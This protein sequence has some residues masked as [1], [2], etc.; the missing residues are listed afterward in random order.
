M[1][2]GKR[3][4]VYQSET[5]VSY[6]YF[7]DCQRRVVRPEGQGAGT[8]FI[9]VVSPDQRV[10][11]VLRIFVADRALAAWREHRG[12]ELDSQEQ[13]V[14]AKMRLFRGFDE[15]DRLSENWLDL[16]VDETNVEEL[17][18]PLDLA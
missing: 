13:Y 8:D 16:V 4:K 7:F 2:A 15:Q 10:P 11:F 14:A 1:N 9:F 3:Y 17:L 12:R 5:G 6:R 18:E